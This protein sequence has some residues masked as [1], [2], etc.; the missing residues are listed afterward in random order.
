MLSW[1]QT[2][3]RILRGEATRPEEIKDGH[4]ELPL[5]GLAIVTVLL[6]MLYGA[7]MGSFS[8]FKQVD[9][10]VGL[11]S[12][13]W[14]QVFASSVKVPALF[15]LTL[16]ITFPSL[17][18]FNSLV[19]S[20]LR[21]ASMLNLLIAALAVNLAVLASMGPIV[22]FFSASTTSYSFMKLLNVGIMGFSG[23]LGLMFLVRTLNRMSQPVISAELASEANEPVLE[24]ADNDSNAEVKDGGESGAELGESENA[25]ALAEEASDGTDSEVAGKNRKPGALDTVPDQI[26][27]HHVKTVFRIWLGV[28]GLVGAQMGWVLRPFLGSPE[29]AFTWFRARESNIFL[30]IGEALLGFFTGS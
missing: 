10:G 9:P 27:G 13:R 24:N 22:A 1:F 12:D 30:A 25:E 29:Q 6:A 11:P 18:V 2:V 26:L 7:C 8:L 16:L 19:G 17:Y 28:F 15:F 20:R 23:L 5:V 4:I 14:M 21:L 3:D